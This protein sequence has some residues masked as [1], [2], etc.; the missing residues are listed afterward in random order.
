MPA[1]NG[2]PL[3]TSVLAYVLA[4]GLACSGANQAL[5][6]PGDT[7]ADGTWGGDSAAAIV[8]DSGTHVH[9]NCTYGDLVGTVPLLAGAFDET[10]SYMLRAYPIAVGPSVPARFVGRVSGA[11][12]TLTVTVNDTVQHQTVVLG[13]VSVVYN[14][15]PRMGPCPICRRPRWGGG[16]PGV[17]RR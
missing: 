9:I 14:A 17:V 8:S 3:L 16:G 1:R 5:P 11:T 10:G 4:C 12:L 13:P 7:L 6:P 15:T 2:I